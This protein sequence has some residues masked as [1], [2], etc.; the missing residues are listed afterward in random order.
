MDNVLRPELFLELDLKCNV[1]NIPKTI[2]Y[3][4]GLFKFISVDILAA[5]IN[6]SKLHIL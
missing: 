4:N 3:N 2:N 5:F 1:I 6:C